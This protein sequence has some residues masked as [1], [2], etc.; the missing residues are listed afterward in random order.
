MQRRLMSFRG[1]R[2]TWLQ[3]IGWR[4]ED[5]LRLAGEPRSR[6]QAHAPDV[7][8]P[9]IVPSFPAQERVRAHGRGAI[10]RAVIPRR[11]VA[12]LIARRPH[13]VYE[14]THT[15]REVQGPLGVAKFAPHPLA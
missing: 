7:G 8:P 3:L 10:L 2:L 9:H 12:R 5:F 15:A 1:C 13:H 14:S 11:V 4:A 6:G